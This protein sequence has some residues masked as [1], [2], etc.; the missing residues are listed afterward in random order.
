ML[1]LFEKFSSQD[2]QSDFLSIVHIQEGGDESTPL[3]CKLDRSVLAA[4]KLEHSRASD[5]A[6]N[7]EFLNVVLEG[8]PSYHLPTLLRQ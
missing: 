3:A 6:N 8:S 4:N 1:D 7:P 5:I 2:H